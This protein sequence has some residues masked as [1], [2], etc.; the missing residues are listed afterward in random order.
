MI[1]NLE[2]INDISDYDLIFKNKIIAII[3]REFPLEK[4]EFLINYNSKNYFLAAQNVH[5]LKHKINML[6]LKKGFEIAVNF[7]NELK[8][9]DINSSQ[10]FIKVLEIIDNYITNI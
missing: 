5:K 6:G 7:E 10:D 8:Q 9:E 4:E 1:P 3:K 2:Y